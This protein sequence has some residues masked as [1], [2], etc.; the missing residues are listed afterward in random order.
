MVAHREIKP[1]IYE[2]KVRWAR[3]EENDDTWQRAETFSQQKTISEYW[4]R[5][6]TEPNTKNTKNI[7]NTKVT[8]NTYINT[9]KRKLSNTKGSFQRSTRSK[10]KI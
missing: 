8:K 2:Y 5:L 4:K 10:Q 9:N 6:G 1:G 3:Y 7:T